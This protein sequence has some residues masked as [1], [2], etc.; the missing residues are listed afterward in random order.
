M[1]DKSTPDNLEE[2]FPSFETG[3]SIAT[4]KASGAN[5]QAIAPV[6]PWLAGGSADLAPSNNTIINGSPS[7]S[8]VD[9]GGRYFHFGIR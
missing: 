8:D 6:V 4:R 5:I 2:L 9:Y 7:I 1:N 3:K